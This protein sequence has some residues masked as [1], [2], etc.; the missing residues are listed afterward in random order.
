MRLLPNGYFAAGDK[1]LLPLGGF[2]A[3]WVGLPTP[4][5]EWD[6]RLSFT[7]AS[8]QQIVAWLTY[9]KSQGV[10]AERFMLRTHRPN[11]MEPMDVGGRVNPG[12]F[13]AFLHY[14]D[15]ARPLG[16]KFLLVVHEDYSKPCYCNRGALETFC[17][18]WFA[19]EDLDALPGFQR[20]SFATAICWGRPP[21]G[22]PIPTPLPART[23]T[24]AS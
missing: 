20:R 14:L 18:P 9:L 22:T 8:D 23:P 10:T 15:L 13:T 19:G 4:D 17:L 24:P 1:P 7:D 21:T 3:N 5:G 6:K 12:L 2:Y 11:G 16:F